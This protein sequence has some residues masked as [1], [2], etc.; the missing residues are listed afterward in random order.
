MQSLHWK[1]VQLPL[2][3]GLAEHACCVVYV[4]AHVRGC[5]DAP[6][7]HH[8]KANVDAFGKV[9]LHH[10]SAEPCLILDK[11]NG[12]KMGCE[13]DPTASPHLKADTVSKESH[14]AWP[15]SLCQE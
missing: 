11:R 5:Y 2:R 12:R 14:I 4:K 8:V 7:S 10:A 9:V 3:D 15:H 6:R 13:H 1:Y